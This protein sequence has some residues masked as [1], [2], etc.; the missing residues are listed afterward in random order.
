MHTVLTLVGMFPLAI[1]TSFTTAGIFPTCALTPK[2]H[3]GIFNILFMVHLFRWYDH[4]FIQ[5]GVH[6]T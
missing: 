6:S 5:N 3:D 1:V 2:E 4:S